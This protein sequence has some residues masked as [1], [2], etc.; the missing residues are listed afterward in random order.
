[1]IT[2]KPGTGKTTLVND[3]IDSLSSSRVKVAMLVTT[4]LGA[5]DLLRMVAY[6]FGL[7]VDETHKAVILQRL[8]KLLV[9]H[10]KEGR[11][12]LLIIDEAQ[13]LSSSALEELR[14]L[15]N[16]QLNNRPLLQIFLLGQE[17]LKSMVQL[18]SLEQL[19]QRLVAA[20][21]L[22]ALKFDETKAYIQHRLNQVGWRSDPIISEAIFP[23]VYKFSLGIPRRINLICSRLLLHG[24]VEEKHILKIEDARIVMTEIHSEHLL[25]TDL[26]TEI[27]FSVEDHFEMPE[28]PDAYQHIDSRANVILPIS[29]GKQPKAKL[30]TIRPA[31]PRTDDKKP[32]IL[33]G[34]QIPSDKPQ[35]NQTMKL[36]PGLETIEP[37]VGGKLEDSPR[38]STN[39]RKNVYSP[40]KSSS[41]NNDGEKLYTGPD[42]RRQVRRK[43]AERRMEIRFE[44][45]KEDR[46]KNPGRRKGDNASKMWNKSNI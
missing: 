19:R 29:P 4:Q 18:P 35:K 40:S 31:R 23:L 25:T 41:L 22:E 42:S 20:C 6:S 14:L 16:L 5:D 36:T 39:S 33:T 46:R 3:L 21:H 11:R 10:Y 9:S 26:P 45:G 17:E 37:A 13:D 24:C 43:T 44:P 15:T 28:S 32:D 7:N 8:G 38:I 12:A 34:R 2:G 1:M 27:D 30:E